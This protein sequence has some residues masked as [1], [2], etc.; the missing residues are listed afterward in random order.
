MSPQRAC[1]SLLMLAGLI[2]AAAHTARAGEAAPEPPALE[3]RLAAGAAYPA[4]PARFNGIR[5]EEGGRASVPVQREFRAPVWGHGVAPVAVEFRALS[6]GEKRTVRFTGKIT[7]YAG[8][9]L[10]PLDIRVDLE[11]GQ[12]KVTP[13]EIQPGKSHQ[14]PFYVRG[15]WGVVGGPEH[16]RLE[17]RAGLANQRQNLY[18]F[19]EVRYLPGESALEQSPEARKAGRLG[20]KVTLPEAGQPA[21]AAR[22]P[23]GNKK[24]KPPEEGKA[25]VSSVQV[26]LNLRMPGR[27]VKLGVQVKADQPVQLT[28]VLRDPGVEFKQTN[29]P[30]LWHVGPL[31]VAAGDWREIVL[32]VPDFGPPQAEVVSHGQANG[33]VD[34][35]LEA[36]H[37]IL[38]GPPDAEVCIDE[39]GVWTQ[40]SREEAL[41]LRVMSDKPSRLLYTHDTL[42]L[43]VGYGWLDGLPAE[44]NIRALLE[45]HAG[46][47][48]TLFEGRQSIPS[49]GEWYAELP[50]RGLKLG[51]YRLVVEASAGETLR[52]A[53][54][55]STEYLV[56][57]PFGKRLEHAELHALLKDRNR[58]VAELG[59][60][61]DQVP[62]PWH[63]TDG[64]PSVE[65]EQGVW[66]FGWIE[67]ACARRKESGLEVLGVLGFTAQWAAPG[68]NYIQRSNAWF[69]DTLALPARKI[70]WEEYVFRTLRR[71]QDSVDTWIVWDHPEELNGEKAKATPLE[72][73]EQLL[74][75][76]REAADRAHPGVKLVSGAVSRTQI[77]PYLLG[78]AEAGA[79]RLLDGIGISPTTAPLAPE[80]GYLDVTLARAQRIRAQERIAP[81]L[82]VLGLD[83]AT[84]DQPGQVGELDQARIV[85]RA[86]VL[87]RAQGIDK[88]L[89]KP[90]GTDARPRRDSAD[91]I[92]PDGALHG[93]KPA[94]L[95]VRAV[96][97][98][99]ES[100]KLV[101]EIFLNDRWEGLARAFLFKAS[102]GSSILVAWRCEGRSL[103]LLPAAPDRAQD[104]FGNALELAASEGRTALPLN[105]APVFAY[106]KAQP[107]EELARKLE[108]S[109]VRF[110][111]AAESAWKQQVVFH[112]D[113]GNEAEERAANYSATD[114]RLVGPLDS[115]YHSEYGTRVVDSGRHFK[116]EER[117]TIE[118]AP[119]GDADI[120]LRKRIN[121]SVPDQLV[122]VYCNG[123]FVGQWMAYKRDR[124]YRWR[125]IAF[126]I[127]QRFFAGQSKAE[128]KFTAFGESEATSYAYWASPLK[129]RTVYISDLPLLVGTSGYGPSVKRDKNVL[130]GPLRFFKDGAGTVSAKG[131]G[132]NAAATIGQSLVVLPLNKQYKRL[133]ARVGIDAATNGRGSARFRV[134]DGIKLIWESK[135]LNYYSDPVEI[136]LDVSD[137]I[138]VMLWV[139][140][141]GD[142]ES[143][144]V[145]NWSDLKLE[146]K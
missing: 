113:V 131:L 59:F 94:A 71:F 10:A 120:L 25:L 28:L 137:A 110:E 127:P 112:L 65:P 75:V 58:L 101:R 55:A 93:L 114:A 19:E 16:G 62:V 142:G 121:Y 41:V 45:D 102:D 83:W 8:A 61:H 13:I 80:D 138:L 7:D 85:P 33:V 134:H 31:E 136:D 64:S 140:D 29:A 72:Y 51:P 118:T 49:G 15:E 125:E 108:D 124:R 39:V 54:P 89:I 66:D 87:C 35:P 92:Y 98:A 57:E 69:G 40:A 6:R 53:L 103:L 74:E 91:L 37:F 129:A 5:V 115:H 12:E 119:F 52:A 27:A 126:V 43:A 104:A 84:G 116:G 70:Y 144:D 60:K 132:T 133:K 56:Y 130:G 38:Q 63:S 68:G 48:I 26:P 86:Y 73:T 21:Q 1:L 18:G 17:L 4:V 95:S 90:D 107:P 46:A 117:F 24:E 122:K 67:P 23:K 106:F 139:D 81:E 50:I 47:R 20:L 141:A 22:K 30:D 145:A 105:E 97:A 44:A 14:P 96:R 34:Y 77:E 79:P 82:W 36:L 3:V 42:A 146:R 11:P 78:L 76:A 135:E 109:P 128:L 2:L 32:P 88:I 99:L 123:Q 111:D 100:A 143:H 9:E